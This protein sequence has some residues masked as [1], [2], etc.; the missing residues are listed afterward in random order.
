MVRPE[1]PS[2]MLRI[3]LIIFRSSCPPCEKM[4]RSSA[5]WRWQIFS[6][7]ASYI[8]IKTLDRSACLNIALRTSEASVKRRRDRGSPCLNPLLH[9]IQ[10]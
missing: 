8:P 10:P 3:S 9:R 2:K 5:Y 4:I 6:F 7:W 1:D